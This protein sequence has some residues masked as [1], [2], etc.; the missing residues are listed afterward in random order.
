VEGVAEEVVG[1][2]EESEDA[3]RLSSFTHAKV[4]KQ[5]KTACSSPFTYLGN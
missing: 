5:Y 2:A 1:G 4:A 3:E